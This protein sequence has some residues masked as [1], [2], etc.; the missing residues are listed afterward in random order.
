MIAIVLIYVRIKDQ[1]MSSSGAFLTWTNVLGK[2]ASA[3][4]IV[5]TTEALG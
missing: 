1:P 3:A 4:L 5:P 2:I